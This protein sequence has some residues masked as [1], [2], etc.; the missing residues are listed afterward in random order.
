MQ[1]VL[2]SV[3]VGSRKVS[4]RREMSSGI[5]ATLPFRL[6]RNQA[7]NQTVSPMKDLLK[8][9]PE[10]VH[11]GY[12]Y[13]DIAVRDARLPRSRRVADEPVVVSH[14][15]LPFRFEMVRDDQEILEPV[16]DETLR[17]QVADSLHISRVRLAGASLSAQ[18]GCDPA[19]VDLAFEVIGVINGR[20]CQLGMFAAS[21]RERRSPQTVSCPLPWE[22]NRPRVDAIDI[23]FRPEAA[24]ATNRLD[25]NRYWKHEIV[26]K[27]VEVD[28][29][30]HH[31]AA[32]IREREERV[33]RMMKP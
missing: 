10:G 29:L 19:P 16:I 18:F 33:Q 8:D 21:Q 17:K 13:L 22:P 7:W 6:N 3:E 20:E 5:V 32:E 12:V 25:I 28:D 14:Q 1:Q 4:L 31:T 11:D 15:R 26:M 23:I 27:D 9:L 2:D 30:L 24:A